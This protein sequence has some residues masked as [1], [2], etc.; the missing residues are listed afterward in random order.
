MRFAE[1][2]E[3]DNLAD[4]KKLLKK[5]ELEEFKW[6]VYEYIDNAKAHGADKDWIKKLENASI[7]A[8]VSRLEYIKMQI[9]QQAE[10]LTALKAEGVK[11]LLTDVYYDKY[12]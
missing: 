4:A 12:I 11:K 6:T 2:I 10:L 8:R 9:Q 1:N 5:D 7:K 3:L